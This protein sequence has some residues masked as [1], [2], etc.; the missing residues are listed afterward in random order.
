VLTCE[1]TLHTFPH[2]AHHA[3]LPGVMRIVEDFL[4][5]HLKPGR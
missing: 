4:A 2:C 3:G 1:T 5:D